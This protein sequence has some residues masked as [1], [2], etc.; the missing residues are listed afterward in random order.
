MS[1]PK[2]VHAAVVWYD[3]DSGDLHIEPFQDIESAKEWIDKP[4]NEEYKAILL[5]LEYIGMGDW[6][7]NHED[8]T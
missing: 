2:Y 5:G 8:H 4:E 1:W 6:T 3:H 7:L